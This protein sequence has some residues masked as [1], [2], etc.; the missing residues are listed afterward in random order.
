ME[1][2]KQET[3]NQL[4]EQ[5]NSLKPLSEEMIDPGNYNAMQ[6]QRTNK[7]FDPKTMKNRTERIIFKVN[8]TGSL[9]KLANYDM[10]RNQNHIKNDVHQKTCK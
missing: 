4:K 1:K 2:S 10:A 9:N 7:N 5:L 3:L 6:F 8:S